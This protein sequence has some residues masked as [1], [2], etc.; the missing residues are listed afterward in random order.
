MQRRVRAS[1][2][3]RKALEDLFSGRGDGASERRD[4]VQL[5]PRRIV[6]ETREGEV[7]DQLGRGYDL[8]KSTV[9]AR[10]ERLWS[11]DQAV[12]GRDLSEHRVLYLFIDGLAERLHL[13]QP[14]E[15]VLAACQAVSPMLTALAHEER[16]PAHA[17]RTPPRCAHHELARATLWRGAPADQDDPACLRRACGVEA[18]VRSVAPREPDLAPRGHQ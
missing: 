14:R 10:T 5:A 18:D 9:S 17:D 2:K 6:E 11:D 16:A 4:L 13:G 8:S 1:T 12:A 15:A 3:R 7:D